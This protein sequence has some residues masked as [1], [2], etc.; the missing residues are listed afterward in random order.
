M[1]RTHEVDEPHRPG[2]KS[3]ASS[4]GLLSDHTAS[5]RRG[6]TRLQ[7]YLLGLQ[8][9]AGN[10][11]VQLLL[12]EKQS[13]DCITVGRKSGLAHR[14][15]RRGPGTE[16]M[17]ATAVMQRQV[18]GAPPV[19]TTRQPEQFATY[20]E[21]L[22]T[23]QSLPTFTSEDRDPNAQGPTGFQVI[24][25]KA[26]SKDPKAPGDDHAPQPIGGQPGDKFIDHPTDKWVRDN[27]PEE[28]RQTAYRLPADCADIAVILRHVWLFAHKRSEH[29]GGFVVGLVGGETAQVRSARVHRDIQGINTPNVGVMVNPYTDSRGRPLRSIAVLGPL[30][31]PGDILL[32][33]HHEGPHGAAADPTRP[34]TGGHTQTIVSLTR[35][36]GSVTRITT[37]QGN[38][39]LPP[40]SGEALRHT[41]GRRIEVDGDDPRDMPIP[42]PKGSTKAAEEVWNLHGDGHTTLVIAGPP[43]SGERPAAKKEHGVTV[44]HVADWLPS[45][46]SAGR[47]T[48]EGRFE[49]AMREA[50]TMAERGDAPA[51][52][53]GEAR[54]VAR[55]AR[56]RLG[57]LDSKAKQQ[58]LDPALHDGMRATLLVLR[59]G[60]TSTTPSAAA[61]VF[62]AALAA[63]DG[64]VA[65]AGWSKAGPGSV[66]VGERTVGHI[67]RI[68]LEGLPGGATRAIVALPAS[69]TGG[70]APVDVL[71]HFH[72]RNEGYESGRDIVID[73]VEEQLETSARR[74]L[75]ILPQG[76]R[77]A[78]FQPFDANTYIRAVLTQLASLAI[79]TTPAPPG[80]V[81]L[82]GHSGGGKAAMDI[83]GG[84]A[85]QPPTGLSEVALFDG[86]NGP[87]ELDV[88]TGWVRIELDK[89]L[90]RLRSPG[91]A[92]VPDKENQVLGSVVFLR[93]YH[94]GS[95]TAKP[96]RRIVDYPGLHASLRHFIAGWFDDHAGELSPQVA[97]TLQAHFQVITTGQTAHD[98]IVGGQSTPGAKS[99]ALQDALILR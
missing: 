91:V 71:L 65:Q 35:V 81:V 50:L 69:V 88:V 36:G 84:G 25:A 9:T 99:N 64:T 59:S 95:A 86:I 93:A 16:R 79:W 61:Q 20:E 32:W 46:A 27:L 57:I 76:T 19:R 10:G 67:R 13:H 80:A 5:D 63:F 68:P 39:P 7:L 55:A 24:G 34:R 73:R 42:P 15:S 29:Y 62:G 31:H 70:P 18:V 53:E 22:A 44:R 26:A 30:L 89:A 48:L 21:W 38:E 78:E 58:P 92:G 2:M 28:L 43:K 54:S 47:D 33:A 96:S 87:E 90:G 49:A 98:Q 82:S 41:P 83:V 56:E 77:K 37:V 6:D 1:T 75:A 60:V 3:V 23:F 52:I 97:T 74:M 14:A 11:A 4:T 51:L 40:Q 85:A 17:P 94:S 66:N 72:G 45:I 12:R 8:R